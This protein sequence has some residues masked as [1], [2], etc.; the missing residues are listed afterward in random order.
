MHRSIT[1]ILTNALIKLFTESFSETR[2]N[3]VIN[4]VSALT[5]IIRMTHKKSFI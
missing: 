1:V 4:Q 5:K 2:I 3:A